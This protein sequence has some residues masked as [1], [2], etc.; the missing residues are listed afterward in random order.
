MEERG[1]PAG[2]RFA[3]VFFAR[4]GVRNGNL[5]CTQDEREMPRQAE[6]HEQPTR[7]L[8]APGAG[9]D[10]GLPALHMGGGWR[11]CVYGSL[12]DVY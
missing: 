4:K 10:K 3:G 2:D 9:F 5:G 6:Y 12:R 1:S 11:C 7:L 8:C